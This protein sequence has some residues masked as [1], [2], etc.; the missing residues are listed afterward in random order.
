MSI[1]IIIPGAPVPKGRP[2]FS[3]WQ[4]RVNVTTPEKT[5]TAEARVKFRAAQ[6]MQGLE[7]I[8]GPVSVRFVFDLP[9]PKSWSKKRRGLAAEGLI[10]PTK[11]PDLDNYEKLILDAFEGL[12]YVD[13]GQ[14]TDVIKTKRYGHTPQTTVYVA[15]IE[16]VEAA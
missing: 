9:I 11:K 14:V 6:A 13:D 3:V 8:A 10:Y 12:V 1:K 15:A 4:G 5:K 16:G 7:P 2:R